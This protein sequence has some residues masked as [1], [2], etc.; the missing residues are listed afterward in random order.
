MNAEITLLK[1]ASDRV[2]ES[3]I[4]G[5]SGSTIVTADTKMGINHDNTIFTLI[6]SLHRAYCIADRTLTV[7][8]QPR[9]E[10]GLHAGISC[11]FRTLTVRTVPG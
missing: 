1:H 7:V 10:K 6:G 2:G 4:I 3:D 9:Q 8:A 5:T 11:L